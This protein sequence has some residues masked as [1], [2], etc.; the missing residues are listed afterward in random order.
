V[1]AAVPQNGWR[2]EQTAS[3]QIAVVRFKKDSRTVTVTAYWS[4]GPTWQVS[5]SGG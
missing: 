4:G 5:D 3:G 2:L 1:L